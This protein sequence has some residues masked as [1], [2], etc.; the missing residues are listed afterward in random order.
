MLFHSCPS[1]NGSMNTFDPFFVLF[2]VCLQALK[3][4]LSFNKFIKGYQALLYRIQHR[5]GIREP[6]TALEFNELMEYVERVN[7]KYPAST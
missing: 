5:Y 2:L 1:T 4:T 3:R 6:S 7:S